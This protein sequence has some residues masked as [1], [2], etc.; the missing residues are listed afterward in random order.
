MVPW[1]DG[2]REAASRRCFLLWDWSVEVK[3]S[4]SRWMPTW[5]SDP[6]VSENRSMDEDNVFKRTEVD[7]VGGVSD[8]G[9]CDGRKALTGGT[10]IPVKS[11]IGYGA[12]SQAFFVLPRPLR[13]STSK[14]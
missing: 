8:S 12:E 1:D 3:R 2:M 14:T 13:A 5:R 7:Q 11:E 6:D 10:S 9:V 4:Q